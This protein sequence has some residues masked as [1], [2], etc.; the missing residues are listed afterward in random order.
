[1]ERKNNKG[2]KN[3]RYRIIKEGKEEWRKNNKGRKS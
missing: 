3:E 2:R 1:M